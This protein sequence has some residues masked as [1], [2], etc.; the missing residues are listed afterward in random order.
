MLI[1]G[2]GLFQPPN[3]RVIITAALHE[4]SG[5]LGTARL[6]GQTVGTALVALMFGLFDACATT[7][8][9]AVAAGIAL[10]AAAV[11]RPRLFDRDDDA[12]C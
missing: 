7:V 10:L 3:N 11:R 9:L 1:C 5:M 2:F 6:L 4:R 8:A 12:R